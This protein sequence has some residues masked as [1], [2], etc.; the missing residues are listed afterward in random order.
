MQYHINKNLGLNK[1]TILPKDI[2]FER[3]MKLYQEHKE[4]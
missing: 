3:V 4:N 1:F 2:D